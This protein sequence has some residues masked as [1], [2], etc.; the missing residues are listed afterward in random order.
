VGLVQDASAEAGEAPW[1]KRRN[2]EIGSSDKLYRGGGEG[3]EG[4]Q[5][6][7]PVEKTGPDW[8]HSGGNEDFAEN[9]KGKGGWS[10][11]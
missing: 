6:N 2:Q 9:L 8:R 3:G 10:A 4:G 7:K 5:K 1:K 11:C